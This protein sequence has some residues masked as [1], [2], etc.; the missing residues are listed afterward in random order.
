MNV[1]SKQAVHLLLLLFSLLAIGLGNLNAQPKDTA[2]PGAVFGAV[3]DTSLNYFLQSA[4]VTVYLEETKQILLYTLTNTLGEYKISGLPLPAKCRITVSYIG[5][6]S[7]STSFQI[8][9]EKPL[10][11]LGTFILHKNAGMLEDVTVTPPPVRMK[12]D[13]LEFSAAAFEL[14]KNAV[15]EDL[16]KKLPGVIVWGDGTITVNGRQ[17]SKLLVNGKPFFGGDAIVATQNIPK[18]SIDKVQVYQ[19]PINPFTNPF[20]SVTSINIK[21]RKNSRTGYFGDAAVGLGT[22]S[23]SDLASTNFAF[24]PKNQFAIVGQTNNV[25]KVS[26]DL[27]SLMRNNTFKGGSARVDYQPDFSIPGLNKQH[28]GGLLYEHYF[29]PDYS[30]RKASRIALNSFV[31]DFRNYTTGTTRTISFLGNDA[32]LNQDAISRLNIHQTIW[33]SDLGYL[34]KKNTD[35]F[36]VKGSYDYQLSDKA[37]FNSNEISGTTPGLISRN[38]QNDSGISRTQNVGLVSTYSHQGFN[39]PGIQKLTNWTATYTVNAG[40]G[41][42]NRHLQS[43]LLNL[44]GP[45]AATRYDRRYDNQNTNQTHTLNFKLGNF[46]SLLFGQRRVLSRFQ[47]QLISQLSYGVQREQRDVTD[48]DT[49][50]KIFYK[51]DYL[52]RTSNYSYSSENA[53][54]EIRRSFYK[55]LANRYQKDFEFILYPQFQ[56]YQQRFSSNTDF[57]HFSFDYAAF[58]PAAALNYTDYQY[59]DYL[60]LYSFNYKVKRDY[61]GAEQRM[62]LPDSSGIYT[63]RFG[64]NN[65]VPTNTQGLSFSFHHTQMGARQ[66]LNYGITL[67]MNFVQNYLADSI[68]VD[69]AGRYLYYPVN[70]NGS[71]HIGAQFFF[72]K[73][74]ST[75]LNQIQVHFSASAGNSRNPGFLNYTGN[76][77]QSILISNLFTQSDSIGVTYT[78][79][80]IFAFNFQEAIALYIARQTGSSTGRYGSFQTSSRAGAGINIGKKFSINNNININTSK[81]S[82]VPTRTY[83]IWNANITYRVL[84]GNNLELKLSALDLLHQNNGIL[85]YGNNYSY[86]NGIVNMQQQ[87]FMAGV[88]FFPRKFGKSKSSK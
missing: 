4:T 64:N 63:I 14:D 72:N 21:L 81:F 50:L 16:L 53:G 10:V 69:A 86:T 38:N 36:S 85:N 56:L 59:G 35:S 24:S 7:F 79:K 78:Y 34:W 22:N 46:A 13:T 83:T 62:A 76:S 67:T 29:I 51:N 20:D 6:A 3:K 70:L 27:N 2:R 84:K 31:N 25:N 47:I 77:K 82:G 11:N 9:R 43:A 12:G 26:S 60:D 15:A 75:R 28:S 57:Q 66:P 30:Q 49:T 33:H 44:Q 41:N 87:Y 32:S 18:G 52:S 71:R 88:S 8:T 45:G 19:E 17:I 40:T 5:Y 23:K 1:S 65:I 55:L 54:I 61:P 58:I 74:F 48:R 73:A 37:A 80:D 42:E 68:A 39:D